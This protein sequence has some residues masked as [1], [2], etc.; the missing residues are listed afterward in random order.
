MNLSLKINEEKG[1]EK[2][3]NNNIILNNFKYKLKI[4]PTFDVRPLF[5][6]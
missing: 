2:C 4:P 3:F 1:V 5:F 6:E